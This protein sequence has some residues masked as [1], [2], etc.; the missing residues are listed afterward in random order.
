MLP[1][2]LHAL[3]QVTHS[4]ALLYR[5]MYLASNAA[6]KTKGHYLHE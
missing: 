3:T 2:K 6:D 5:V 1:L 4:Y